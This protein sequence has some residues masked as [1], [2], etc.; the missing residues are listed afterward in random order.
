MSEQNC[1]DARCIEPEDHTHIVVLVRGG[2][3]QG[4]RRNDGTPVRVTVHDYDV[5]DADV[6]LPNHDIATD[7]HGEY[8]ERLIA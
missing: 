1:R 3:V 8:F 6:R 2:C 5:H 7:E 4:A